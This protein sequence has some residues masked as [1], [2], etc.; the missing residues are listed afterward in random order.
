MKTIIICK[1]LLFIALLF[2]SAN[3]YTQVLFDNIDA[4]TTRSSVLG[5]KWDKISL[6]YYVNHT[7][8]PGLSNSIRESIIQA[9]FQKWADVS[10][11]TFTKTTNSSIAD[12][13]LRFAFVDGNSYGTIPGNHLA[14]VPVST[15]ITTMSYI[16]LIY[17]KDENWANGGSSGINMNSVTLHEIGHALGLGHSDV[18]DAVMYSKYNSNKIN[19][20]QDDIDGIQALYPTPPVTSFT[21]SSYTNTGLGVSSCPSEMFWIYPT[22]PI[23]LGS[24][25]QGEWQVT[26]CAIASSG[27]TGLRITAPSGIY[28]DFTVKYRYQ[29]NSGWSTWTTLYGTTRNCAAGED[30]YRIGA[31]NTGDVSISQNQSSTVIYIQLNQTGQTSLSS[32]SAGSSSNIIRLY[33]NQGILVRNFTSS[34]E[35]I[36]INTSD[37]PNGIYYLH[38]FH[39]NSGNP[40][41]GA[42]LI[43]H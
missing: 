17:D 25:L 34:E 24:V 4:S 30:P 31:S 6:T 20:T 8:A 5:P 40:Y 9:A 35:N 19:L 26:G 37:L 27:T 1:K 7:N 23:P 11:F 16:E 2:V 18:L 10:Y 29:T 33:N 39:D 13:T 22:I 14:Y 3:A 21:F 12:I 42:L 15:G 32:A 41:T 38:V 28:A 36:E 43:N